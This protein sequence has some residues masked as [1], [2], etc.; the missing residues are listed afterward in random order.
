MAVT[1][2]DLLVKISLDTANASKSM[3]ELTKQLMSFQSEIKGIN[4]SSKKTAGVLDSIGASAV[5][6]KAKFDVAKMAIMAV[7]NTL[8]PMIGDFIEA[9]DNGK[10]LS[11][12]LQLFG[13]YSEQALVGF[14]DWASTLQETTTISDDLAIQLATTAKSMGISNDQAKKMVETANDLSAVTGESVQSAFQGLVATLKGNARGLGENAI[15]VSDLTEKQL[16]SGEAINRISEIF[17]GQ[18]AASL[19]TFS[20]KLKHAANMFGELMESMGSVIVE[21]I[22]LDK[23]SNLIA[24]TFKAMSK[25]I[26]ENKDAIV[27]WGKSFI[28]AIERILVLFGSLTT[29]VQTVFKGMATGFLKT[30]QAAGFLAE[31]LGLISP[32]TYENLKN[33]ADEMAQSTKD[34]AI[35]TVEALKY[36]AFGSDAVTE[37]VVKTSKAV[38]DAGKKF[39]GMGFATKDALKEVEGIIKDLEKKIIDA[40]KNIASAGATEAEVIEAKRKSSQEEFDIIEKRLRQIGQMKGKQQEL[41]I[42]NRELVNLTAVKEL[43]ALQKKNLDDLIAKNQELYLSVNQD[44]MLQSDIIDSQTEN[45]LKQLD[46]KTKNLALDQAG[47]DALEEQKDLIQEQAMK[48]KREAG[49]DTFQQMSKSGKDIGKNITDAFKSGTLDFIGGFSNMLSGVMAAV[50]GAISIVNSILDFIPKILDAVSSILN[51][52]TDLPNV[53][54]K[55][56]QG[57]G[58][59]IVKFVGEFVPNI[60]KA[61]PEIVK[62]LVTSLLVTLPKVAVEM[63]KSLPGL[64]NDM[65]KSLVDNVDEFVSG[66]ISAMPTMA[67]AFT[68]TLIKNAPKISFAIARAIA[69]EVP[70]AVIKGIIEGWKAIWNSIKSIFGKGIKTNIDTKAIATF[71]K[72][73]GKKLS[74]ESSKL[75]AVM[76]LQNAQLAAEKTAAIEE[77][78]TNGINKIKGI[79]Q[80]LMDSLIAT[81]KWIYDNIIAPIFDALKAVW[82][83]VYNNVLMPIVNG[84]TAVW[85]WVNT[86]IIQPLLTGIQVAFQWV[87]DNV[88]TPITNIVINAFSWVVNNIITP[89]LTIGQ[90]AFQWVYDNIVNKLLTIG[91]TSFQWVYENV[92][93]P[94]LEVGKLFSGFKMPNFKWPELPKFTWPEIPTPGWIKDLKNIGGGGGGGGGGGNLITKASKALGFAE[95]GLVKTL[96]AA[97]GVMVPRGTDTVPAMLTPGEFVINRGAV[98][99]LGINAMNSINKGQAPTQNTTINIDLKI[100]T[101]EPVTEYYVRNRL[102]PRLRDELRRASLD[103][104]FVLSAKGVR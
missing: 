37:S 83:W 24:D 41:L 52:I 8:K 20:G 30:A 1:N 72:D 102:M 70:K 60:L 61:I 86:N 34:S 62:S 65:I 88:I 74:G 75:F 67:I 46:I 73:L 96:Y 92:V 76:D 40:N 66:L 25:W 95:G 59:A 38:S 84:L 91:Q 43:G 15:L 93:K 5:F 55:S 82:L 2:D 69:I 45:L 12:M 28:S 7:A 48:Q 94:L 42:Q 36:A 39:K 22:G 26:N 81:W 54:L 58:D 14:K 79:W 29:A 3:D 53:I 63:I 98:N 31:K 27:G 35:I 90:Q 64:I 103:G 9:E 17:K 11:N 57:L 68:E 97:D 33:S 16:Q 99:N 71:A 56:V 87:M 49:S 101:S 44:S 104:Q 100:D 85:Q 13:D 32:E 89:I 51:K 4:E 19:D 77:A 6:L 10:K 18:G 78:V 80:Q 23:N 50:D 21:I 47:I